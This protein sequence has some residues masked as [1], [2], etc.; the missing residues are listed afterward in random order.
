MFEHS[1]TM[2][3]TTKHPPAAQMIINKCIGQS[4]T[5]SDEC[6]VLDPT[7]RCSLAW[8]VIIVLVIM[9]NVTLG[10]YDASFVNR[11][12]SRICAKQ[13][14]KYDDSV[15]ESY[16]N[17]CPYVTEQAIYTWIS[18]LGDALFMVDVV[19][20]FRTAIV[21]KVRGQKVFIKD[22]GTVSM[23]YVKIVETCENC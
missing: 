9:W 7:T 15:S 22:M 20:N 11:H 2:V 23:E 1:D 10:F 18:Y 8:D 4:S 6:C 19:V 5:F 21:V 17:S 14:L 16:C 12:N 13:C 3:A